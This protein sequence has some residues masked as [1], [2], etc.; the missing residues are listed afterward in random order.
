MTLDY[1][2]D[3]QKYMYVKGKHSCEAMVT[4]ASCQLQPFPSEPNMLAQTQ[5]IRKG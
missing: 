4:L 3:A 1:L 2:V 5:G